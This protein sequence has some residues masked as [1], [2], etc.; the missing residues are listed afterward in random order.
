MV[1]HKAAKGGGK[2]ALTIGRNACFY[3]SVSSIAAVP[4]CQKFSGL[5][6]YRLLF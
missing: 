6:Q 3:I 2:Q 4:N 1:T 5:K